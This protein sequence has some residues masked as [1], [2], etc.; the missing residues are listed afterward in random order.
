[1]PAHLLYPGV[2]PNVI[3]PLDHTLS[4]GTTM[5]VAA[6]KVDVTTRHPNGSVQYL[7]NLF[8]KLDNQHHHLTTA[9]PGAGRVLRVRACRVT[10][11]QLL[12]Q[13]HDNNVATGGLAT[14]RMN[15][16]PNCHP[17]HTCGS[18]PNSRY[19]HWP[20]SRHH[21]HR[22]HNATSPQQQKN[23]EEWQGRALGGGH[24]GPSP[25]ECTFSI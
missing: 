3:L 4:T 17:W 21:Q 6:S 10:C 1:M 19:L 14:P 23:S 24:D 25:Q 20:T 7:C 12:T 22:R 9:P 5:I 8:R 18:K 11:C 13:W 15:R 2:L 16:S